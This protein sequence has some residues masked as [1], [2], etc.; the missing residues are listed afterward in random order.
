MTSLL[1]EN[2]LNSLFVGNSTHPLILKMYL[3]GDIS[4]ETLVICDKILE[5][6]NDFDAKL[7]DPVW[8]SVS[9]KMRKYSSFLNI[10][11]AHYKNILKEIVIHGT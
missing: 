8:E 4:L 1:T 7:T 3:S 10:N 11:T 5:Y 6:R 2:D 9:L